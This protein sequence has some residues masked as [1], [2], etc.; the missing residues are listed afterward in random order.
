LKLREGGDDI[1]A[2]NEYSMSIASIFLKF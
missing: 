1:P 2:A